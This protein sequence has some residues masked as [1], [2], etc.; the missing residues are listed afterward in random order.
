MIKDDDEKKVFHI[1]D[2]LNAY[3]F[4]AGFNKELLDN[5][6][7]MRN[8]K[9]VIID[10]TVINAWDFTGLS[11]MDFITHRYLNIP[12]IEVIEIIDMLKKKDNK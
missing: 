2:L 8:N 11:N 6:I 3:K 7:L 4:I 9:V 5:C 12:E 1:E 10:P